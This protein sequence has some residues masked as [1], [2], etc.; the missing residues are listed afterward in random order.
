MVST[1]GITDMVDALSRQN[2]M[3]VLDV[4]IRPV[5]VF[6]AATEGF[7]YGIDPV[8]KVDLVIETIWMR[9]WTADLMPPDLRDALGIRSTPNAG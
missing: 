8:S 2:F 6:E 4:R 1:T 3:T 9:E 5:N 7:I